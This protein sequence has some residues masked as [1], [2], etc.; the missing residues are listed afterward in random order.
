MDHLQEMISF[1]IT[2]HQVDVHGLLS[3]GPSVS[4]ESGDRVYL[5]GV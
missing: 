4:R 1:L 5:A 3:T 2:T